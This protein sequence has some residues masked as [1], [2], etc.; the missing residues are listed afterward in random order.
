MI[1][2]ISVLV[3]I[4]MGSIGSYFL[5][6]RIVTEQNNVVTETTVVD[7]V[8]VEKEKYIY[9]TKIKYNKQKVDRD[10]IQETQDSL[11]LSDTTYL[12]KT[13]SVVAISLDS[14]NSVV[15]HEKKEELSDSIIEDT[16]D[17]SDHIYVKSGGGEIRVAENELLATKYIK[18]KGNPANFYCRTDS[19]LDSLLVDNYVPDKKDDKIRVE[20]WASPINTIGYRLSKEKLVLFGFYD[21]KNLNLYYL[22]EGGLQMKYLNNTYLLECGDEFKTLHINRQ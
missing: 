19:K 18:P 22:D 6:P 9:K 1:V 12:S 7:T 20:I 15:S 3:G 8:I 21:F 17:V 10:T 13:D 11:Q 16:N 4:L 14:N 5:F 2:I